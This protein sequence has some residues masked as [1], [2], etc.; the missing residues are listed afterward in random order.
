MY[1]NMRENIC[2]AHTLDP[3]G[4]V[5]RSKYVFS[6]ESAHVAYQSKGKKCITTC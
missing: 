3:F 5:K 6:P 4:G 1:N 2:L